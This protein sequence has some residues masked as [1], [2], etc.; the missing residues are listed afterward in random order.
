MKKN[1]NAPAVEINA[2]AVEDII[3]ASSEYSQGGFEGW[4]PDSDDSEFG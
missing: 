2:F 3:T 1:Y 4:A